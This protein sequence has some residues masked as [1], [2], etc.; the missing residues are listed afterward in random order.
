MKRLVWLLSAVL[1]VSIG[2]VASAQESVSEVAAKAA[3]Q[4][5][6]PLSEV[7]LYSS[8]VGYF[9][10]DGSIEGRSDVELRFKVD[11]INDLLK[12]MVIQ[13]F[14]GGQVGTV[15]YDSRDP[16][17]KT[18]KSFA[19][20]LTTHPGLGQLLEQ[21]RGERIEAATPNPVAG[22]VIG[23][24]KKREKVSDKDV[25]E[26]EYLNIL[27]GDGLRSIPLSQVQRI[28]ITNEQ[29][30][31]ELRQA[32]EV[33]ASSHDLQKKSVRL[34][35]D[36]A[37]RR[38]VR[39]GY[40]V[41]TPVWKTSYRL[42]LSETKP[43]YLQG[44]AIVENTTDEDWNGI[45][46]SLV[47]GRPISFR[48]DL[49]EPLFVKR[50]VVVSELYESLRPQVHEQAMAEPRAMARRL[51][52][53][54]KAAPA[55]K[56]F[57]AMMPSPAPPIS[58]AASDLELQEGVSSAALAMEAGE[59]FRYSID[60][61]IS[62]TRQKSA[63]LPIV[64]Q[65][66]QGTKLAVYNERVHAKH[67]LNGF[68]L[69]N[70]TGL[71]LMQGPIT[72]FEGGIYAGDARIGDLQPGQERI[73]SYAL[74]LKTEVVPQ[75]APEK[76]E[77]VSASLRKG[78]LLMTR[79]SVEE[80]SYQVANRDQ[81]AKVVFVEHPL[82][83][84]W[85]LIEPREAPERTRDLYRFKVSVDGNGGATLRVREEKQIQQTVRLI[86]SGPDVIA[87]YL[88]AKQISPKV[89]EALQKVIALRDRVDQI[90]AHR[91]RLEQRIKEITQEQG[92]IRENMARVAQNSELYG[93]YVRKLDQQETEI[94]GL[95]KE[96]GTLKSTEEKQRRELNDFLLALDID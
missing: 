41:E 47:S 51:G 19:V 32:L 14:D 67:P 77:V 90:A 86:D 91:S 65:E 70:S 37:G 45:T 93:R 66:V 50:P 68:R 75:A 96:I 83:A 40:I 8:G 48:M 69:K 88:Q 5:A 31:A 20:D 87:Y 60:T 58:E 61:P 22:V 33:L 30:K 76:E 94:E 26:V 38:R 24:E 74:D 89:K 53:R 4:Q 52:E 25:G 72:V 85:R 2:L 44:W 46:L 16:I 57:G 95:R 6:L 92:R 7:V 81:K 55:M 84:D 39:V 12:S 34:E 80:K 71:H 43:P 82:R 54:A 36:G 73:I 9:Q 79:K 63:M 23:V 15:T 3:V 18:L 49:Y 59:L 29:L 10:R 17:T 64:T 21:I 78:T 1:L 13:D 27:T 62:L 42:A 11:T 56:P 28:Q 35:F